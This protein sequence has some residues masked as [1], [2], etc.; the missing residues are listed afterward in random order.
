MKVNY[1]LVTPELAREWLS[2]NKNNRPISPTHVNSYTN[3]MLNGKWVEE[4]GEAIKITKSGHVA[5]GQ[6]RLHAIVKSGL[7]LWFSVFT[8]MEESV[9]AVLDSGKR[10]NGGDVLHIHGVKNASRTSSII[11]SA[12]VLKRGLY[13]ATNGGMSVGSRLT[14]KDVLIQYNEDPDYWENIV[15]S[16]SRWYAGFSKILTTST[17]G[18]LYV[19]LGAIDQEKAI[20]FFDQLCYGVPVYSG[21]IN[22]LRNKLIQDMTS[23]KKMNSFY[24]INII[25]KAWN[26]FRT[27]KELKVLAYNPEIEGKIK[28]I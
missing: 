17:I 1:L 3:E 4:T 25:I 20:Q 14:N 16:A 21:T 24:R 22:A 19:V 23:I 13:G 15:N 18:G 26:C 5:D 9:I 6:H 12:E 28:P 11:L 8:E 7:S 10:R 27:G 2:K